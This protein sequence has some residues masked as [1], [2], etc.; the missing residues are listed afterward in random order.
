MKT[1]LLLTPRGFCAGVVRAIDVVIL[2]RRLSLVG[3]GVALLVVVVGLPITLGMFATDPRRFWVMLVP[4]LIASLILLGVG[5]L[6]KR[7]R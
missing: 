2:R 7:I 5:K 6:V 4:P 1:V 3:Y